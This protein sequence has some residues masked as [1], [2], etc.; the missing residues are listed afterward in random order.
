M[1]ERVM[2]RPAEVLVC[3]LLGA[4]LF[5]PACGVKKWPEPVATE[6]TFAW[7]T[8]EYTATEDCL[9]IDATLKGNGGNLT[10]LILEIESGDEVCL[11]CPFTP[12]RSVDIPL[13]SP[14][15]R[16]SGST[17]SVTYCLKNLLAGP[18]RFRLSGTNVYPAI[19]PSRSRV[20]T[21]EKN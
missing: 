20:V 3:L 12:E 15:V 11:T 2:L 4:I 1:G 17:L 10:G 21:V 5:L 14:E 19:A 13:D 16:R 8:V 7:D 6:D 18:I 9:S